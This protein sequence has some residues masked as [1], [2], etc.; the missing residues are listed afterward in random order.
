MFIRRE[1]QSPFLRAQ[2]F[3]SA[4][5][6]RF[7]RSSPESLALALV[8]DWLALRPDRLMG[9]ADCGWRVA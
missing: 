3:L 5:E 2:D 4:R 8:E 9:W 6:I 1:A 7:R